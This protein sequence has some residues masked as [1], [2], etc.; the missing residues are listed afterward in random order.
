MQNLKAWTS[1][2]VVV[3]LAAGFSAYF[4]TEFRSFLKLNWG[5]VAS[6]VGVGLSFTAAFFAASASQAARE[7][8]DSL[9]ARTLEQ[10]INDAHRL[11]SELIT[12]V[13]GEQF[14]L[15]TRQC[16]ELLDLPTRIRIRW[17]GH[18][19]TASKDNLIL[20]RQQLENIHTVLRKSTG[21]VP[22]REGEKLLKAC[23]EVRTIFVQEQAVI[24]RAAD[25][26]GNGTR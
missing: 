1:I 23:I 22:Q 25:R 9:L 7:A 20:A 26:G 17:D 2:I 13:E 3:G 18:L 5:N 11:V 14:Q 15:A 21:P 19:N 4:S 16:S 8:R 24:M 6:V 10:E 12:L